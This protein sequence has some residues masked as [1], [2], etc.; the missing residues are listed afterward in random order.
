VAVRRG[1]WD[2]PTVLEVRPAQRPKRK[3]LLLEY[4]NWISI[5]VIIVRLAMGAFG[6]RF[7]TE[8][9]T[10]ILLFWLI[11]H[12]YLRTILKQ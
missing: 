2:S 12:L 3:R 4:W 9:A 8:I 7:N 1:E 6:Y 5:V 11:G 10:A